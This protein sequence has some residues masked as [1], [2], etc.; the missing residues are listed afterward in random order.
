MV[1]RVLAVPDYLD[2]AIFD[3]RKP[4]AERQVRMSSETTVGVIR[5]PLTNPRRRLRDATSECRSKP[6]GRDQQVAV[7]Y[8]LFHFRPIDLAHIQA[9]PDPT[10]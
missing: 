3:E 4:G 6:F 2:F 1:I 9:Q 5:A 10:L 7:R 8:Q